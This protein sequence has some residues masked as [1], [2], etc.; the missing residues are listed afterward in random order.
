MATSLLPSWPPHASYS[1]NVAMRLTADI[2]FEPDVV[3]Q[4][5]HETGLPVARVVIRVVHGD[6]DLKLRR[7]DPAY[8]LGRN[9]LVGV[10]RAGGVEEG[11]FVEAGGLHHQRVALVT[12]VG[13]TIVV[14]EGDELLVFR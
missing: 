14:R 11:L 2:V 3:A 10:G 4:R 8:A 13:M 5:V 12:P 6:N 1:R 9:Q 7:A